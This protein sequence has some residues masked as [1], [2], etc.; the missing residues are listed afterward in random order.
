MMTHVHSFPKLHNDFL[1]RSTIYSDKIYR[2]PLP[3]PDLGVP[4]LKP[5][6]AAN[7]NPCDG[8][9][10]NHSSMAELLRAASAA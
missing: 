1:Q 7:E 9:K 3:L 6:P 4:N 2:R 5:D 8:V 10:S